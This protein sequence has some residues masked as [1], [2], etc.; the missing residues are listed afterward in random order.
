MLEQKILQCEYCKE[1]RIRFILTVHRGRDW[2]QESSVWH[3]F[4]D[5]Q[6]PCTGYRDAAAEEI[7]LNP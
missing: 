7:E 1:G 4:E 5:E 6:V 3:N 2:H